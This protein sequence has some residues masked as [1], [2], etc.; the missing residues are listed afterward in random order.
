[1]TA[2]VAFDARES[3]SPKWMAQVVPH[4]LAI[5]TPADVAGTV[6]VEWL[7]DF[8]MYSVSLWYEWRKVDEAEASIG[9]GSEAPPEPEGELSIE[10]A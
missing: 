10:T 5:K 9:G 1:M 6:R 4:V 7:N 8:V 3:P 2:A